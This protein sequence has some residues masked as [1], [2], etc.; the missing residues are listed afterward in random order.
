VIKKKQKGEEITAPKRREPA[1]VVDLMEAL[2]RSLGK[3]EGM[4][5]EPARAERQRTANRQQRNR[6]AS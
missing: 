4:K 2:K 5:K 6:K 1:Q 3:R